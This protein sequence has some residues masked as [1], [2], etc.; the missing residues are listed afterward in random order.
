MFF[1]LFCS[2]YCDHL[3]LPVLPHSFPTRRSSDLLVEHPEPIV[4]IVIPQSKVDAFIQGYVG[5]NFIESPPRHGAPPP[6]DIIS[7]ATVTLMV[8]GD[9]ITR[10]A[11]AV[12]R[13]RD[14]GAPPDRKSTRL[15]S[16]H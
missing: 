6:V 8:I 11:I 10:S 2:L 14:I 5:L 3:D 12:A 1:C 13:T 7:G 16:S 4:L 9:S 15:N